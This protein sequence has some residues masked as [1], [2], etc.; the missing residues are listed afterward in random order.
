M[1]HDWRPSERLL[2][3]AA[4]RGLYSLQGIS[5]AMPRSKDRKTVRDGME[6]YREAFSSQ[7]DGNRVFNITGRNFGDR[8]W[9]WFL[10][11]L[12]KPGG[13]DLRYG[14]MI[15]QITITVLRKVLLP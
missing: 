13:G 12:S 5:G 2:K 10:S 14:R 9:D 6:P 8:D 15:G 11:E 3:L 4:Q 1:E 7:R